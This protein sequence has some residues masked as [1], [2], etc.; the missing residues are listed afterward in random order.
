MDEQLK[1][2]SAHFQTKRGGSH[3]V[4]CAYNKEQAEKIA[5]ETA[6][7]EVYSVYEVPITKPGIVLI[8][9]GL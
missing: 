7:H 9:G 3:I 5:N 1:L 4:I 6:E 2:Y 8:Y